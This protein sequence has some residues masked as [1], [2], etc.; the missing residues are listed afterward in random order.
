[1][2]SMQKYRL[3]LKMILLLMSSFL[4]KKK[5][6]KSFED[7]ISLQKNLFKGIFSFD[8]HERGKKDSSKK[9]L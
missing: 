1:M 2:R 4:I 7:K 6:T 5:I 8:L 9:I 3:R